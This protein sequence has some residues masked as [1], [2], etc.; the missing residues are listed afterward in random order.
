VQGESTDK[1]EP[2]IRL[3]TD[4]ERARFWREM[5]EFAREINRLRAKGVSAEDAINDVRREL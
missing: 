1:Q 2:R 4:E 5:D 3:W